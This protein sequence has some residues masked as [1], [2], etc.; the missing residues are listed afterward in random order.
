MGA[1]RTSESYTLTSGVKN[2]SSCVGRYGDEQG[3]A[4]I[5]SFQTHP[6]SNLLVFTPSHI[7]LC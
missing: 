7:P 4:T 2:V 3:L 5:F 1:G 6:S